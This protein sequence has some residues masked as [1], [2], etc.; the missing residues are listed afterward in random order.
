MKPIYT[1][2]NWRNDGELK[3]AVWQEVEEEIYWE[4]LNC[5]PPIVMRNGA[6]LVGEPHAHKVINHAIYPVYHAFGISY[7]KYYFLGILSLKEFNELV[8]DKESDTEN[9]RDD[10]DVIAI[11]INFPK[12]TL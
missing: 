9:W 8:K 2:Q 5:L 11:S 1:M 3:P 10:D 7:D 12:G 6:F 4:Q